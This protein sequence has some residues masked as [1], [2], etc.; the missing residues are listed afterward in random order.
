MRALKTTAAAIALALA[1]AP[2]A[3][4]A[5][6]S[7]GGVRMGADAFWSLGI[8]GE[9]QTVVIL[10]E[11]F[12]ALDR[13]IAL[14]ELPPREAMTIRA[15]DPVGGLDGITEF[16]Q[17]TQHGVRMAEI[18]HDI[19][20]RAHL[21]LIAYRTPEQFEQAADW[22]AAAG[23]PVVSHSN[24]FLTPPF[25]GTGR[26]ARAVDRT[27]AAGVLWVN[28]AGNYGQRHWRGTPPATGAVIPIAPAPGSPLLFSLSWMSPA[29]VASIAV[30]RLDASGIWIEVQR[31]STAIA[32]AAFGPMNAT[33]VPL[34]VDA[35]SWRLVVRQ[36]SG[37]PAE[38]TLFS[39][40][41]GF[42]AMAVADGSVPTPGDAA[43]ALTV[44]AVKWT[45]TALEPYSSQG[46]AGGA[47]PDLVAPTYVT[48][49]PEWPGT[50]G[51]SAATAHVAGA[52]A[53]LRQSR[54]R[55]G[56]SAL[57]PDLRALLVGT[58]L[59]LGEP[60][61]DPLYGAGMARL[62]AT[63]PTL[64][65]RIGR[66]A[67]RLLRVRADD[68]GTIR[69]VRISLNGRPLRIVRRPVVGVRLPVS[70]GAVSTLTI[71]VE[72]MAGNVATRVRALRGSR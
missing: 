3:S 72:D 58:A 54:L 7:Q 56:L 6:V 50:A 57:A 21:A 5:L 70:A 53:L 22:I 4:G 26:S 51:T 12:A 39:Q 29:V 23:L 2:T 1:L 44:G 71:R 9:G 63:P 11:G 13:S 20:P 49:N 64:T 68:A 10:D 65:V 14:G 35:S 30:E 42:G 19:A 66:G 25:D 37:L 32:T 34:T 18:V 41:V 59:D 24:S 33:T 28:S 8:L 17:P 69:D 61:R 67:R 62:D 16:G 55:A 47:K 46:A 60:G 48:S 36:E 31:S 27:A 45:G 15:F 52:A 40:T 43:G 38:L